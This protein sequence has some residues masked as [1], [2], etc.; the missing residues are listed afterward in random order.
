MIKFFQKEAFYN[1]KQYVKNKEKEKTV[2]RLIIGNIILV[3]SYIVFWCSRFFKTKK[4]IIVVDFI[5]N[6]LTIICF[7]VLGNLNGAEEAG[8]NL[9][10]DILGFI[11]DN[12]EKRAKHILFTIAFLVI[13]FIYINDYQGISTMFLIV[14]GVVELF[15]Y[16]ICDE[17]GMRLMDIL[18]SIFY[19]VF[20][21][22]TETYIGV[23]CEMPTNYSMYS[24]FQI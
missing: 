18:S 5:Q 4:Q 12:K 19:S 2:M 20:L 13:L 24:I 7:I 1:G 23:L 15:G 9:S 3:L 8:Y 21:F 10:N 14:A 11:A 6:I 16:I 17:Q 22:F